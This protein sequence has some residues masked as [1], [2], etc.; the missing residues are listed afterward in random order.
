MARPYIKLDYDWRDD[1]KVMLYE[2][3]HKKAALVDLVT[4]FIL[5][6]DFGGYIDTRNEGHML[7]ACAALRKTRAGALK[8]LAQ[9]VD[10]GLFDR[11]A[12][13]RSG[14]VTS[15]RCA[16]DA[17]AVLKRRESA[18]AASAAAAEKRAAQ[19]QSHEP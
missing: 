12:W 3:R 18:L 17:E 14:I 19:C 13:E 4:V 2:Q 11:V 15:D 1:P 5:A 9:M 8:S 16:R 6:A 7:K 10:C